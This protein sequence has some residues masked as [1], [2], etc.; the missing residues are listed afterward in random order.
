MSVA[1]SSLTSPTHSPS[2]E[3]NPFGAC[4]CGRSFSGLSSTRHTTTA[5]VRDIPGLTRQEYLAASM[6]G[7]ELMGRCPDCSDFPVAD[8]VDWLLAVAGDLP[9][10]TVV[11]RH[12]FDL[13]VR[14]SLGS[15]A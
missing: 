6:A 5:L 8:F 7:L 3:R 13:N 4:G 14:W 2:S 12:A 1:P 9:E 11:E 10:G 15:G